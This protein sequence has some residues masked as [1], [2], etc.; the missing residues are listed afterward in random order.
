[1]TNN[2]GDVTFN[3]KVFKAL[4]AASSLRK[5][6]RTKEADAVMARVKQMQQDVR[7]PPDVTRKLVKGRWLY[8]FWSADDR[9]LYV[10]ITDRGRTREKE[11]ARSKSWWPE[12]HHVT[13]EPVATRA[14]LL[15]LEREAIRKGRP[16]Y[17]IQHN[18]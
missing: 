17:N 14:E 12:V 15:H 1:M 7:F 4:A 9:L 8:R 13:V 5:A 6:G 3:G 16:K 10:G 2:G 11:H 18:A